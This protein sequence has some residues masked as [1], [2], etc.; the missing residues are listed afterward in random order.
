[1]H[2]GLLLVGEYW[3]QKSWWVAVALTGHG[4]ATFV[5]ILD[6]LESISASEKIRRHDFGFNR[7][8][9][10]KLLTF[11]PSVLYSEGLLHLRKAEEDT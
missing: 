10:L 7:E 4:D 11:L 5:T 6:I 3:G 1:M 9:H 8:M 2:R